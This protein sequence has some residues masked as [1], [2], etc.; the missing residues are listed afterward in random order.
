MGAGK[1]APE[2]IRRMSC[3]YADGSSAAKARSAV[4]GSGARTKRFMREDP[5]VADAYL[6]AMPYLANAPA[7]ERLADP[8]TSR[9]LSRHRTI[10]LL[11]D[12]YMTVRARPGDN[13][14]PPYRQGRGRENFL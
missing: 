2:P 1:L 3:A 13:M 6:A 14:R 11:R 10:G 12:S 9:P 4:L 7:E 5:F 8:A